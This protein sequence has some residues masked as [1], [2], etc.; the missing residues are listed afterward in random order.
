MEIYDINSRKIPE[1]VLSLIPSDALYFLKNTDVKIYAAEFMDEMCGILL[2]KK[3][4]EETGKLL[5]INV[6]FAARELGLGRR[7][8][9][10]VEEMAEDL[11]VSRIIQAIESLNAK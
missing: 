1:D 7:L 9:V 5:C 8:I 11:Y 2:W 3:E 10:K 6:D 4:S